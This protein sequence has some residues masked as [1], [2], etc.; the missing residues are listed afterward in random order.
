MK[1]LL[2]L[3]VYCGIMVEVIE[4]GS[5][6]RLRTD[7]EI[8][9]GIGFVL[10]KRG[11]SLEGLKSH[12]E[13]YTSDYTPSTRLVRETFRKNRH[14][15]TLFQRPIFLVF[16]NNRTLS[17]KLWMFHSEIVLIPGGK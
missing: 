15:D 10:D 5:F 1:I 12:H 3:G 13:I 11:N 2:D 9:M 8:K 7:E 4:K 17:I 14:L 16:W 6:V